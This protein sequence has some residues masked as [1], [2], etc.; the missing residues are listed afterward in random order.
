MGPQKK[1]QPI[2]A[3]GGGK[4]ISGFQRTKKHGR[5]PLRNEPAVLL[6]LRANPAQ[7]LGLP[8]QLMHLAQAFGADMSFL[9]IAH[10]LHR[11]AKYAAGT[12]PLQNDMI[13]AYQYFNRIAF[14]HLVSFAQRF[15]EYNSAELVDFS[16]YS[17][18]FHHQFTSLSHDYACPPYSSTL[19][20]KFLPIIASF[21]R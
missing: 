14:V 16:Y 4:A 9:E 2:R 20:L 11:A 19:M 15:R 8:F 12:I 5:R 10:L 1:K 18:R 3:P 21:L 6:Q 13:T 7:P 17:C